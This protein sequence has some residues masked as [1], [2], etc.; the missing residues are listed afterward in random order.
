[1]QNR[2]WGEKKRK[3]KAFGSEKNRIYACSVCSNVLLS[4]CA[5]LGRRIDLVLF[6]TQQL[7]QQN[8]VQTW[9]QHI[10]TDLLA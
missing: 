8:T 4:F 2:K 9:R 7:Q 6:G 3:E 5:G 10:A 1:M